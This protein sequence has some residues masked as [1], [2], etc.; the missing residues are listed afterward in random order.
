MALGLTAK[1]DPSYK[2]LQRDA[3]A[4]EVVALTN[5]VNRLIK[6]AND[7]EVLSH[8][9]KHQRPAAK[10]AASQLAAARRKLATAHRHYERRCNDL[11]HARRHVVPRQ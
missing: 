9:D 11:Q 8:A 7:L 6:E 1:H 3:A 10:L 5:E 2:E 4:D